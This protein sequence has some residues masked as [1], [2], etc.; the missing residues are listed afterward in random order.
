MRSRIRRS[1]TAHFRA[2]PQLS[3]SRRMAALHGSRGRDIPDREGASRRGAVRARTQLRRSAVS[4]PANIAEGHGRASRGE[5]LQHLS[6]AA[7]SLRELQTH[8]EILLRLG[9]S[10]PDDLITAAR[11]ADR[12]GCMLTRLRRRLLRPRSLDPSTPRPFDLFDPLAAKHRPPI[13]VQNLAR[14][15]PRQIRAQ[16]HDRPRDVHSRRDAPDRN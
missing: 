9:Y 13:H 14:N 5:Y 3:R 11:L 10:A 12:I 16:E 4:V 7:G 1:L 15:V 6:V 8:L 2:D